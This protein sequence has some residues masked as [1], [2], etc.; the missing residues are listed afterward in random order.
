MVCP[1]FVR[2]GIGARLW[3]VTA[4]RPPRPRTEVGRPLEPD[5]VADA[6]VRAAR[7]RRRLVVLGAV[8][9]IAWW[10]SRLAPRVYEDIMIRRLAREQARSGGERR[11]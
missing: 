5:A 4:A 3:A 1:S 9:R 6:V 11:R 8:G 2:T 10:V 7:A